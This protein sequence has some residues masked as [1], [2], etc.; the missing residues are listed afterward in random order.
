MPDVASAA[1]VSGRLLS[2]GSTGLGL[3]GWISRMGCLSA[4]GELAHDFD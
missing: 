1:A 2:R 3:G 4:M